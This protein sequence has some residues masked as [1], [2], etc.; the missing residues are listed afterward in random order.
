MSESEIKPQY[1]EIYKCSFYDESVG[2]EIKGARPVLIIST[3]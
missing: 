1:G 3:K 2:T